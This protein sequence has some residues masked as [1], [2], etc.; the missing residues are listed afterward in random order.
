MHQF[1]NVGQH[2]GDGPVEMLRNL[3]ADIGGLVQRL[4]QRLILDDRDL[5]IEGDL[6]DPQRQVVL[7]FGEHA[8]RGHAFH[9][10]SDGHREMG[11][12]DDHGR[13]VGN[14]LHHVA[15]RQVALNS[16]HSLFDLRIAFGFF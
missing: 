2:F 3:L 15:A 1:V 6:A 5:V 13:R 14:F 7:A 9:L 12:V 11:R 16:S 10:V 4:G 8:R